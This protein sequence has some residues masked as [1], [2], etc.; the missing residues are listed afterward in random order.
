[1]TE[2]SV[3]KSSCLL[4]APFGGFVL[5][6]TRRS[7]TLCSVVYNAL[8]GAAIVG[9]VVIGMGGIAHAAAPAKIQVAILNKIF[10]FDKSLKGKDI[11]IIAAFDDGTK[12]DVDAVVTEFSKLGF[13]VEAVPVAELGGKISSANVVYTA[14]QASMV[15]ELC[16]ANGVLSTTGNGD[17]VEDGK[18]S[19]GVTVAGGKPAIL[20]NMNQSKA[21]GH[22]FA[23]T[24]LKL[25]K[26]IK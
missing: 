5:S 9:A 3:V 12:A 20:V 15:G 24:L 14:S 23:V 19:V 26:V 16:A 4:H 7:G 1:M 25:A 11:S 21:E 22:T 6:E 10:S 18:I 8:L 2:P 13:S 17:F